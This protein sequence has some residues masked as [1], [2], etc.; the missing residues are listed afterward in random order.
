M[1]EEEDKIMGDKGA[2]NKQ[3]APTIEKEEVKISKKKWKGRALIQA[4]YHALPIVEEGEI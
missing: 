1:G 2:H 3:K 4:K